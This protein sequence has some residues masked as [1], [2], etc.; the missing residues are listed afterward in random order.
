MSAVMSRSAC[1]SSVPSNPSSSI[2]EL[3][4]AICRLVR[5]MN[6][7]SYRMLVLV[8]EFDDRLGFAKWT[9][10]TCAEWLAWRCGLSLSAAREKVRTAQALRH[11]PAI[12]AAFADGRL[13]YTKVRAL[14]R[15]ADDHD[16]DLLLGYALEATAAQVK[17]RCRQIR[18]ASPE[19]VHGARR[20]WERRCLTVWR[21]EARGTLRLT[22]ELP[23]D[24]GEVIAR[25]LDCAVA[26]GEVATGIEPDSIAEP[27]KG[28]AWRAQQA[29]ALVAVAKAYLDGGG[30]ANERSNTADRYQVVVRVDAKS[31]GG[32]VGRA[33]LPIE[34]IRRLCCDGNLV[35][36][37]DDENGEPLDV[38][39]KQRTLS[40]PLR[41]A[42]HA[43]DRGCTFPGCH[44]RHYLDGH[45]LKHWANGGETVPDNLTLLCTYH[46]RLLHEGGFRVERE[47]DG[48]LTFTRAD[49]RVIPRFGYRVEDFTDDF[50]HDRCDEADE[51]PPR[52][53]FSTRM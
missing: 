12:S 14:T 16:E 35:A 2:D 36:V 51:N 42:L 46:H 53:D 33:D 24:E 50:G 17:E 49:G 26:A 43:R 34:T 3:D 28:I 1:E 11:L 6:A 4:R 48:T 25:A 29:D 18:H 10:P 23:I 8:R 41:R 47:A 7:E 20:A 27:S 45:H 40:T 52:R 39:R 21:D 30:T 15:V 9:L 44:R 31:L 38:G 22:V 37:A 5:Q 19:S 13:S 32:G